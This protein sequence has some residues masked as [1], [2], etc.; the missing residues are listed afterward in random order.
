MSVGRAPGHWGGPS[1]HLAVVL[2]H[3][4]GPPPALL[5]G[6]SDPATRVD[7]R[8]GA[9]SRSAKLLQHNG[10]LQNFVGVAGVGADPFYGE[11]I[12]ERAAQAEHAPCSRVNSNQSVSQSSMSQPRCVLVWCSP[13]M[14]HNFEH[15]APH[16][17]QWS[18]TCHMCMPL[19][20]HLLRNATRTSTAV[21]SSGVSFISHFK[22]LA[23]WAKKLSAV[24]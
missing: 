8:A 14:A 4:V 2:R 11:A 20:Q 3:N 15:N 24:Q 18:V 13:L 10:L 22:F 23:S 1:T 6:G 7:H 21:T 19:E 16:V 9:R 17:R 12:A 5:V